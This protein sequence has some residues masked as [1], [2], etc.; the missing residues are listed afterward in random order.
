MIKVEWE[1][2][3]RNAANLKVCKDYLRTNKGEFCVAPLNRQG[4]L[5]LHFLKVSHICI[6]LQRQV[7]C[8]FSKLNHISCEEVG[9]FQVGDNCYLR[10][11]EQERLKMGSE[12]TKGNITLFFRALTSICIFHQGIVC[13]LWYRC[14][15]QVTG[16]TIFWYGPIVAEVSCNLLVQLI[17]I[18]VSI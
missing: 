9:F 12:R 13:C 11:K 1:E 3:A 7:F 2:K 15:H 6:Q 16:N 17:K 14:V 4:I 5:L 8:V 18:L 10:N